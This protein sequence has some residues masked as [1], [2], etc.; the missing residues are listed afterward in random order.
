VRVTEPPLLV[1]EVAG[2]TNPR[3]PAVAVTTIPV[4]TVSYTP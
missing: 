2:E 3:S 4:T 1:M